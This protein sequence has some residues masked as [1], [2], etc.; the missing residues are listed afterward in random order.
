MKKLNRT[1]TSQAKTTCHTEQISQEHSHIEIQSMDRLPFTFSDHDDIKLERFCS[2][3][4]YSI[5]TPFPRSQQQLGYAVL[6]IKNILKAMSTVEIINRYPAVSKVP[7]ENWR[8]NI[9]PLEK[10]GALLKQ[11]LTRQAFPNLWQSVRFMSEQD[12]KEI[13]DILI[14]KIGS[15]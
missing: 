8:P 12:Q 2:M 7:S 9:K 11:P 1:H 6:G 14:L 5:N 15:I 3:I 13:Y 4:L 10:L